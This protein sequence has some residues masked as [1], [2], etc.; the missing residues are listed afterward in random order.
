MPSSRSGADALVDGDDG[1]REAADSL[2]EMT[3]GVRFGGEAGPGERVLGLELLD[4]VAHRAVVVVEV[5]EDAVVFDGGGEVVAGPAAGDVGAERVEAADEIG[6]ALAVEAQTEGEGQVA[7]AAGA[8]DDDSRRVDAKFVGVVGDPTQARDAV[9]EAGRIGRDF[10]RDRGDDGVA[11]LNRR[12]GDA[13]ASEQACPGAGP[14]VEAGAG[15]HSAAVDRVDAGQRLVALGADEQDRNLVAVGLRAERHGALGEAVG[16]RDGLHVVLIPE[17]LHA[18]GRGGRSGGVGARQQLLTVGDIGWR[19]TEVAK[20]C[21]D[22]R[23]DA[24]VVGDLADRMLPGL[25][26]SS[27]RL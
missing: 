12:D 1:G 10:G 3:V 20:E 26:G 16:R 23:V 7:A 15:R 8:G 14:I 27:R 6:V 13:V 2:T 19:A 24:G 11:E 22:S 4:A 17:R 18:S 9:V 25:V 5:E 21:F